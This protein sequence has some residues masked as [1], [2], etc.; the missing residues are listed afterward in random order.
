M[1]RKISILE[2]VSKE[3][4]NL[5]VKKSENSEDSISN[6]F[7]FY[8]DEDENTKEIR[9]YKNFDDISRDI[10]QNLNQK[11]LHYFEFNKEIIK[12]Y[13]IVI[14]KI[15]QED[16]DILNLILKSISLNRDILHYK[17][18][19]KNKFENQ[20]EFENFILENIHYNLNDYNNLLSKYYN[21]RNIKDKI[22]NIYVLIYNHSIYYSIDA[23][24]KNVY[25]KEN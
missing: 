7:S 6:F 11:L 17:L 24:K 22:L 10:F 1:D 21:I 19:D 13:V 8:F 4:I 15:K 14:K 20:I 23:L 3:I 9:Q 25:I 16:I 12:K 2:D 18:L 5:F